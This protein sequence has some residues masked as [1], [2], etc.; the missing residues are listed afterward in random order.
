MNNLKIGASLLLVLS[1]IVGYYQLPQWLGQ[2]VSVLIRVA[3]VLL[4]LAGAAVMMFSSSYGETFVQFAKGSRIELRKM[5]WPT[6]P[7]TFQFTAI[8][9][10]AAFL[11]AIFLWLVDQVVFKAIYDWLLSTGI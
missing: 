7:E 6:R 5:V 3:F 1:A 10:V 9:I 11:V 8:I 4:A 2:E